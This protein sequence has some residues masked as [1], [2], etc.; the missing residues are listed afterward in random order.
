MDIAT[1]QVLPYHLTKVDTVI[2]HAILNFSLL[3]NTSFSFAGPK[4][5]TVV[6][7]LCI[8]FNLSCICIFLFHL[9]FFLEPES[10]DLSFTLISCIYDLGHS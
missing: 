10:A 5:R 8:S 7:F 4:Q 9:L 1:R 3:L 6:I 2:S